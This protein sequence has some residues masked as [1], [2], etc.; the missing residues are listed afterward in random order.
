[1][2]C[3]CEVLILICLVG[4]H[5]VMILI[6]LIVWRGVLSD[7][8]V[9]CQHIIIM[10]NIT[11]GESPRES[12][13]LMFCLFTIHDYYKYICPNSCTVC[14][15][16]YSILLIFIW[17]KIFIFLLFPGTQCMLYPFSLLPLLTTSI[18]VANV[19]C[20]ILHL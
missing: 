19:E 8:S 20:T 14:I 2:S 7:C 6:E 9:Y 11:F 13:T 12:L 17:L 5:W 16:E 4:K 3:E 10:Y 18:H 1:M 15:T